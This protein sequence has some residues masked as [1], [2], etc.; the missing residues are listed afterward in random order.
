MEG[1]PDLITFKT[2]YISEIPLYDFGQDSI[3]QSCNETKI[4]FK[5]FSKTNFNIKK[6][7]PCQSMT[8]EQGVVLSFGI[9]VNSMYFS[10]ERPLNTIITLYDKKPLLSD[11]EIEH[12]LQRTKEIQP[13]ILNFHADKI[14]TILLNIFCKTQTA[15]G[16]SYAFEA[17]LYVIK[18]FKSQKST[19]DQRYVD[20]FI[21]KKLQNYSSNP[22]YPKLLF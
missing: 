15:E 7:N 8:D 18:F 19:K 12:I 9:D 6:T 14:L 17:I 10:H 16:S 20:D 5:R 13:V 2:E 3:S 1:Y 4:S 11:I 22:I 21:T